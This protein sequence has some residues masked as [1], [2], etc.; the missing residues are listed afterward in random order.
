MNALRT[1]RT[2]RA[3]GRRSQSVLGSPST[4]EKGEALSLPVP[5]KSLYGLS[6]ALVGMYS[7]DSDTSKCEIPF[8][9]ISDLAARWRVSRPA[10]YGYLRG[11]RVI[12]FAPAPGRR[13]HKIVSAE[14]VRQIERE[15]ERV[16]R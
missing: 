9:S 13:G 8:F 14:V 2:A 1:I 4:R 12:D 3:A 6:G 11:Y 5:E 15:R 7:G 16:M 10:V